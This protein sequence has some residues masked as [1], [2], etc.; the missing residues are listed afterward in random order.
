LFI[1][2]EADIITFWSYSAPGIGIGN[3][4]AI[5]RIVLS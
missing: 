3:T 4:N 5:T 1:K 2:Q